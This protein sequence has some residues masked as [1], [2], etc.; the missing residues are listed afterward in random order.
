VV[1]LVHATTYVQR[2]DVKRAASALGG[3]KKR[4]E[5]EGGKGL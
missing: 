4:K 2:A 3:R 1:F 5:K